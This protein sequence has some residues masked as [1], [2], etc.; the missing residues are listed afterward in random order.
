MAWTSPITGDFDGAL[1]EAS[2]S[3]GQLRGQDEP[4]FTALAAYIAALGETA[5]GRPDGA[6]PHLRETR[7]LA[8]RFDNAWLTLLPGCSWA[9]WPSCK[10]GQTN[11]GSCWM[12]R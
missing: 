4:F 12:R 5:L 7:D 8:D 6:L 11:P 10:A 1:R 9:H 3:P 2:V